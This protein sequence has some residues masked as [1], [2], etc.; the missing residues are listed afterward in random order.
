MALTGLHPHL[1]L[2]LVIQERQLLQVSRRRSFVWVRAK[3]HADEFPRAE[4]LNAVQRRRQDLRGHLSV[5]L[6]STKHKHMLYMGRL[7][8]TA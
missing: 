2:V 3:A 7:V 4:V 8:L 5:D 1:N 6:A